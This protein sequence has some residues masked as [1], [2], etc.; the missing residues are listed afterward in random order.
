M[1][2]LISA[3]YVTFVPGKADV[4]MYECPFHGQS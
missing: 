2:R 3:F 4:N 1:R